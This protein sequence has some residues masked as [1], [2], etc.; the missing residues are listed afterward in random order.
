MAIF[1]DRSKYFEFIENTKPQNIVNKLEYNIATVSTDSSEDQEKVFVTSPTTSPNV[2]INTDAEGYYISSKDAVTIN[3]S[4]QSSFDELSRYDSLR[5]RVKALKVNTQKTSKWQY[6]TVTGERG[7]L[8]STDTK[9]TYGSSTDYEI[10]DEEEAEYEYE[11]Y[12]SGVCDISDDYVASHT[13]I[14]SDNRAYMKT[15]TTKSYD[16]FV[17]MKLRVG[18]WTTVYQYNY[19]KNFTVEIYGVNKDI[20]YATTTDTSDANERVLYSVTIDPNPFIQN[21]SEFNDESL[22]DFISRNAFNFYKG[23]RPVATLKWIGS[24]EVDY[25]T[26]VIIEPRREYTEDSLVTYVVVGKKMSYTGGYGETLYLTRKESY[27]GTI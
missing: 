24:P 19:Y 14:Y 23:G 18:T 27:Y 16:R 22:M 9:I 25:G 17:A 12:A 10:Y 8:K 2:T 7:S 20:Q 5:Y 6:D 3:V 21:G 11:V 26:E 4:Y 1:I 15:S 13:F